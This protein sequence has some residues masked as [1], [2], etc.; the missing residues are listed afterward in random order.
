ML[1]AYGYQDGPSKEEAVQ[2]LK[3]YFMSF[4]GKSHLILHGVDSNHPNL[5]RQIIE[6][7]HW[8]IYEENKDTENFGSMSGWIMFYK[9]ELIDSITNHVVDN[10]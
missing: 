4:N 3:S 1:D 5:E 2:Q 9:K 8:I 6:S 10:L 7:I